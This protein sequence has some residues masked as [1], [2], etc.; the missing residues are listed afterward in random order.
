[1]VWCVILKP[2][3]NFTF[4]IESLKIDYLGAITELTARTVVPL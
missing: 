3:D 2:R 1:M 4:T